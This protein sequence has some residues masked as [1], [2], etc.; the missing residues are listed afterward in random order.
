MRL[1]PC[2]LWRKFVQSDCFDS[3]VDVSNRYIMGDRGLCVFLRKFGVL[4]TFELIDGG[5]SRDIAR[6]DKNLF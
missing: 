2:F 1:K 3:I 4:N 6:E 5:F